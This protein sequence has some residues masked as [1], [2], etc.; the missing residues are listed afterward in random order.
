MIIIIGG[1]IGGLCTAI[2]LQK[3]GIEVRVYENAPQLKALGAGL[4]LAGNAMKALHQI[5]IGQA[6]EPAG[7]LLTR[8]DILDKEGRLISQPSDA[9]KS[10]GYNTRN[11]AIHRADLHCILIEQLVP[12]TLMLGKRC[13]HFEQQGND[14]KVFFED[15]TTVQSDAV[16]FADGIHSAGRK[17]LVP[18]ARIRY[19]G[20]TCWRA[21]IEDKEGIIRGPLAS[22]TWGEAGRFGCVPLVGNRVYWFACINAPQ[23]DPQMAALKVKDLLHVF[24]N[25]HAPI[26]QLLKATQDE[27]LIWNDIID[28]EPVK[29]FAFERALLIG[30][31]GHATTPNLGQ[32]ACQAIEDAVVLANCLDKI[33]GLTEAFRSFEKKR[34]NRTTRIVNTSWRVGQ[35]AHL[36]NPLLCK[37][38]NAFFRNMP[39]SVSEKQVKFLLDVDFA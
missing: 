26:P 15:G 7:H 11:F 22:E 27:Q 33:P 23:N 16:I 10:L 24:K 3:K 12:G 29:R 21:V 37:L 14:V 25:Y 9:L 6:I 31:A 35:I 2:A 39:A 18:G 19:A 32:G 1:G 38:R 36:E 28:F 13:T 4:V 34:I 5:G 20:Y 8:M 30:D 17:Q